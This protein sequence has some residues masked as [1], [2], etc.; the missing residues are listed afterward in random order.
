MYRIDRDT[1]FIMIAMIVAKRSTCQRLKVGAVL[2]KDYRPIST[3]YNGAPSGLPHCDEVGCEMENGACVRTVHAEA[4]A[5]AFAA[6][7]GIS[8]QGS[9]LYTTNAP[10]YTCAKLIINAGVS[11]VVFKT[12]YRRE[13]GVNLLESCGIKVREYK[14]DSVLS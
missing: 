1:M 12:E 6:K 4:N 9:I 5:I 11:E 13:E 14:K 2:V 8:T 10:C 7:N 3:G